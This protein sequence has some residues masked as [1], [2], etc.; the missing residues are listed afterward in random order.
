[1]NESQFEEQ[2]KV[3]G[4]HPLIVVLLA[5]LA[6]VFLGGIGSW[7][8]EILAS[9]YGVN[10]TTLLQSNDQ[11]SLNWDERQAIRWFNLLAHVFAFSLATIVVLFFT[12]NN[13]NILSYLRLD[14][15]FGTKA[16]L[17]SVL[18]LLLVFPAIQLVF[19]LN[20]QLPLPTGLMEMGKSQDWL[21]A[22]VLRMEHLQELFFVF[23]VAALVPAVG[24]ELLFRGLLQNE[25]MRLTKN[26]H[27]SIWAIA[28]LFSAIHMQF[29]GFF[30]RFLL[31]ALLG[32]LYYWSASLWL[33]ILMHFLF[34]GIQVLAS[35][36]NPTLVDSSKVMVLETSDYLLG[37]GAMALLVPVL[38]KIK[39]ILTTMQT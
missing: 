39:K 30:P 20:L 37:L 11:P 10:M 5:F 13:E 32:Y 31:G 24:E 35:F 9:N 22:E 2:S 1:M 17:W 16:L 26:P 12:R 36:L 21:V 34:N 6:F 14:K 7:L 33:P 19:W 8:G 23:I 15:G 27:L 4:Y 18:V 29:A 38:M 28:F 3:D 25:F